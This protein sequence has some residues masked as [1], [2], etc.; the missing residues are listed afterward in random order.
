MPLDQFRRE[1]LGTEDAVA[2]GEHPDFATQR[3]VPVAASDA[4]SEYT[5]EQMR[6]RGRQYERT[7]V[8]LYAP[9]REHGERAIDVLPVSPEALLAEIVRHAGGCNRQQQPI[10][11][12]VIAADIAQCDL[13]Q[14]SLE[15]TAFELATVAREFN[16]AEFR[17]HEC[18]PI[19]FAFARQVQRERLP[20]DRVTILHACIT[21]GLGA[22]ASETRQFPGDPVSV[23]A[24]LF[25]AQKN[26]LARTVRHKTEIF[27]DDEILRRGSQGPGQ[28]RPTVG[29][30][31]SVQ[32]VGHAQVVGNSR[33]TASAAMPSPRPAKPSFSLVVALTLIR[34]MPQPRSAARFVHI[35]CA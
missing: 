16:N 24:A 17:M 13:E 15:R 21:D 2:A 12:A 23:R 5:I 26:M 10:S 33:T 19:R 34:S 18:R 28:C 32:F 29:V 30:R 11:G 7:L 3:S 6:A 20:C 27:I 4:R 35:A 9:A 14:I 8:T 31:Q 25:H 22:D 1:R